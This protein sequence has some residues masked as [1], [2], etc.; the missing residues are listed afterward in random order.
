MLQEGLML[1]F[2]LGHTMYL[3]ISWSVLEINENLIL[4]IVKNPNNVIF[5]KKTE[6]A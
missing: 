2:A 6:N 4:N 1:F 5:F 3:H